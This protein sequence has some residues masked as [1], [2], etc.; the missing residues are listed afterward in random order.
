MSKKKNFRGRL[1][2][3]VN[4][5]PFSLQPIPGL[6]DS[7]TKQSRSKKL[8]KEFSILHWLCS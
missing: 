1:I 8:K 4:L 2:R 5:P 6:E 3:L 7:A